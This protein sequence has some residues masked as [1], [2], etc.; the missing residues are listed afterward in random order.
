[1]SFY[2]VIEK[3]KPIFIERTEQAS[4]MEAMIPYHG[5]RCHRNRS[6]NGGLKEQ[7]GIAPSIT[8]NPAMAA[9]SG[10]DGGR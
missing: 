9:G 7:R 10:L 5:S 2:N 1:M 3:K 6:I 4:A 8:G